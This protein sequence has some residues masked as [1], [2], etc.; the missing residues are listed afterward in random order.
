MLDSVRPGHV[1]PHSPEYFSGPAFPAQ[2]AVTPGLYSLVTQALEDLGEE[3]SY[4]VHHLVVVMRERHLQV[5]SHELG[6]VAVGVTVLRAK[7]CRRHSFRCQVA[8]L[9]RQNRT[10][11]GTAGRQQNRLRAEP[12]PVAMQQ[13]SLGQGKTSCRQGRTSARTRVKAG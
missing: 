7:H 6:Q 10:A 1:P 3:V 13:L 12:E 8:V 5:Q 11:Q 2:C 9:R 4:R